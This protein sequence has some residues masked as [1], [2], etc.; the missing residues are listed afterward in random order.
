[1]TG[2]VCDACSMQ[3]EDCSVCTWAPGKKSA[4]GAPNSTRHAR[5]QETHFGLQVKKTSQ[6]KLPQKGGNHVAG[7]N[8]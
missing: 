1:M 7:G 4:D 3:K 6:G 2:M 5:S 8:C